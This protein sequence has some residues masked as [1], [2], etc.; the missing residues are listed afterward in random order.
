MNKH[1]K[2]IKKTLFIITSVAYFK[3]AP[4]NYTD[5][6]SAFNSKTRELQTLNTVK[7][8]RKYARN[9]EIILIESGIKKD[10]SPK[11]LK[12]INIYIYTGDNYFVR[13]ACDGPK[14]GFGE[15]M[16]IIFGLKNIIDL[17]KY[18]YIFK[19]SGRYFLNDRFNIRSFDNADYDFTF[20]KY[21]NPVQVST[22]L[23]GFFPSAYKIWIKA[24]KKSLIGLYFNKSI[25]QLL[26]KNINKRKCNYVNTLGVG[27]YVGPTGQEISE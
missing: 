14:K 21:D 15:A 5:K 12:A 16:S 20:K 6:R 24:I 11:I 17:D 26:Y 22:R 19:I 23:Y 13:K 9:S 10:I 1:K 2:N 18:N 4:Q 25:E 7:S 27:G 3:D 8:I